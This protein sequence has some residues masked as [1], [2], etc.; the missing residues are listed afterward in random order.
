MNG[1]IPKSEKTTHTSAV[2][3]NPSR[4]PMSNRAGLTQAVARI[5][6]ARVTAMAQRNGI[7]SSL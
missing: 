2:S 3:R 1:I 7:Q 6:T 4:L 5:P